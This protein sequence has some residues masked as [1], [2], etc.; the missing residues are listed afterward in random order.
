MMTIFDLP[1]YFLIGLFH[2]WLILREN[3]ILDTAC[4]S[5]L[6]RIELHNTF[7][8]RCVLIAPDVSFGFTSVLHKVSVHSYILDE[9]NEMFVMPLIDYVQLDLLKHFYDQDQLE[10]VAIY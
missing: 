5:K 1:S 3:C 9:F 4:C 6:D 7:N 8:I 2:D 10:M